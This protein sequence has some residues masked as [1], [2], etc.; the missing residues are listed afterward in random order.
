MLRSW[1]E[2]SKDEHSRSASPHAHVLRE[3]MFPFLA[4]SHRGC[5]TTGGSDKATVIIAKCDNDVFKISFSSH[6]C[7]NI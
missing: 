3:H 6:C 2:D 4:T 7:E 5:F 1:K